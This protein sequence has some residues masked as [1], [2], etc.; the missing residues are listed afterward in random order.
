MRIESPTGEVHT[1]ADYGGALC[2]AAGNPPRWA[3]PYSTTS[4][5]PETKKA[6]TCMKCLKIEHKKRQD[7]FC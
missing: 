2:G 3:I 4:V 5:W 7:G 6:E 1:A